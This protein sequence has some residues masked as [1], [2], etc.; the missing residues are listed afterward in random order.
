MCIDFTED[1][2]LTS[3]LDSFHKLVLSKLS[4]VGLIALDFDIYFACKALKHNLG[5]A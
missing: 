4:I 2:G 1:Y 5:F 3:F